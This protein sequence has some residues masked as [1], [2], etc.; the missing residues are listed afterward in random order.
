MSARP[1]FYAS[2]GPM[3]NPWEHAGLLEDLPADVSSLTEVV[4]GLV[5]HRDLAGLYGVDLSDERKQDVELRQVA[6][7][8]ARIRELEDRPLTEP[9]PYEKRLCGTCRDFTSL[10]VALLRHTGVPARARCG[11]GAY[12]NPGSLEDHWV[13]EYWNA[14]EQ[15]WQLVDAQIDELQRD[16]LRLNFD[17]L[18]VPRDQFLVAGLAWRQCH[19]GE[20]DPNRCG[21]FDLRGQ[22]FVRANVVRDLAALNK[23]EM[24]PW[25]A[26]GLA[27]T[28]F[29]LDSA[30][31][32]E[33]VA[34]LKHV[35]KIS[36][37]GGPFEELRALYEGESRLRVPSVIR[38]FTASGPREV[39]LSA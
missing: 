31:P 10:T 15:R 39:A 20:L 5:I 19:A 8:L 6:P 7:L 22:W 1:E 32:T 34:L 38:S 11:F 3:T 17:P 27:D 37:A 25:D 9:R 26:W 14:D 2:H 12:F 36:E 13:V 35:A 16:A 24:L 30:L 23:M 28:G 29:E 18:H 4:Q 21:I 33:D